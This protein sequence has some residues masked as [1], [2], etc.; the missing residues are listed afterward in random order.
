[1]E[2]TLRNECNYTGAVPYWDWTK[3]AKEG[4]NASEAFDGS[5]TSLSGNGLPVNRSATDQ[6]I[7]SV[8]TTSQV[9]KYKRSNREEVMIE[10]IEDKELTGFFSQ[11]SQSAQEAAALPKGLSPT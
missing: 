5:A 4:F 2:Q 3:T 7:I 9:G 6:V 8:N 11:T 1:M 10:K